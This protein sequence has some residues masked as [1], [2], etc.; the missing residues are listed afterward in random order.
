MLVTAASVYIAFPTVTTV[1]TLLLYTRW[2][3][4]R[5]CRVHGYGYSEEYSKEN[6]YRVRFDCEQ[7]YTMFTLAWDDSSPKFILVS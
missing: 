2:Q 7:A 4:A 3:V 5:F 6:E 1:N